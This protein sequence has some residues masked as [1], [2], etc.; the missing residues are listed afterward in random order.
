R[1]RHAIISL[2]SWAEILQKY[3]E[4]KPDHLK[5]ST[6]L[7]NPNG[8][9]LCNIALPWFWSM[10]LKGDTSQQ[11]WMSEYMCSSP[12]CWLRAKAMY[13]R[14]IEEDIPVCLKMKWTVQYFQHQAKHGKAFYNVNEMEAKPGHGAY[15]E[16]QI[17]IWNQFSE[18]AKESFQRLGIVV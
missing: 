4:L 15:A 13:N 8:T 1:A 6:Q 5:T 3:Q 12:V 16:R 2:G 7:M 17:R 18:Q 14:W 10:D 9:G 11:T